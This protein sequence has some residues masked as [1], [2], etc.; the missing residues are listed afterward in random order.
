[1]IVTV[2][3]DEKGSK[4]LLTIHTLFASVT[5]R[6][7]HIGHGFEQGT[8]SGLDQLVDYVARMVI[9]TGANPAG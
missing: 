5:M 2:T 1:M 7:D 6:N 3:F 9:T 8:N 4:T